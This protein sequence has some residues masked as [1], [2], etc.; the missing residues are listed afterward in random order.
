[1]AIL[2][3][4][5]AMEYQQMIV[6]ILEK[7]KIQ[8]FVEKSKNKF[9]KRSP[10]KGKLDGPTITSLTSCG[11][12]HWA[13]NP[14]GG[15][16]H[17]PYAWES[18]LGTQSYP[19]PQVQILIKSIKPLYLSNVGLCIYKQFF[20]KNSIPLGTLWAS[21]SHSTDYHFGRMNIWFRSP[22]DGECKSTEI[23][24]FY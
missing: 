14:R 11:H 17:P 22:R 21:I 20:N 13:P 18:L 7:K 5:K 8:I 10:H 15:G 12:T 19:S 6:D 1:M 16:L 9:A 3:C 2:N 4:T 23:R 24:Y